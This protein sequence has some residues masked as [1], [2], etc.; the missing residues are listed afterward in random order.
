MWARLHQSLGIEETG[1]PALNFLLYAEEAGGFE[2][3]VL[4]RSEI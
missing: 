2:R 1:W 3:K 4:M